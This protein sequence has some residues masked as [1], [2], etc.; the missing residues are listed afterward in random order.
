MKVI[1]RYSP[2]RPWKR[3]FFSKTSISAGHSSRSSFRVSLCQ[4][5]N[6]KLL[7]I[8]NRSFCITSAYP[9]IIFTN[10]PLTIRLLLSPGYI[11][12]NQLQ[13]QSISPYFLYLADSLVLMT[14]IFYEKITFDSA[15]FQDFGED[16]LWSAASLSVQSV[17]WHQQWSPCSY[18][19][20]LQARFT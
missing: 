6:G 20:N 14:Y 17:F 16:R 15:C 1:R 19:R 11:F 7:L 9:A 8:T 5:I 10:L 4:S 18:F 12:K 3:A 13:S 2:A